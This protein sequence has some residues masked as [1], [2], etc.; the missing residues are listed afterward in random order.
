MIFDEEQEHEQL[1][2][3]NSQQKQAS[4]PPPPLV[5]LP[6]APEPSVVSFCDHVSSIYSQDDSVVVIRERELDDLRELGQNTPRL[7]IGASLAS[8]GLMFGAAA[9]S[10]RENH[11]DI[12]T[13]ANLPNRRGGYDFSTS[14]SP[15]ASILG[16][17]KYRR[18]SRIAYHARTVPPGE[19]CFFVL[20]LLVTL[21]YAIGILTALVLLCFH[22]WFF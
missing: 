16:Q 5:I 8:A 6:P 17:E 12:W 1:Q 3:R 13:T 18:V 21:I 11:D 7:A 4:P 2:P 9:T 20:L 15:L 14:N 19:R 22:M 10:N